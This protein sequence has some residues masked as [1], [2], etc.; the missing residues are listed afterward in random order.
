MAE[1]INEFEASELVFS[2]AGDDADP[3]RLVQVLPF[4][5]YWKESAKETLSSFVQ[6]FAK[7]W[8]QKLDDRCSRAPME[9]VEREAAKAEPEPTDA[10]K[11]AGNYAKGHVRLHGFDITIENAKGNTRSGEGKDGKKWSVKMPAAYGYIKGTKGKDKDHIDV[12]VGPDEKS[13]AVYVIDQQKKEGGFD[14]HKIMLGFKDRESAIE[15]YD[16][17]F[18]GDLGP[19]LRGAVTGASI[20][21]LK[22]WL[23]DGDTTKPYARALAEGSAK[24]FVKK[25]GR[26]LIWEWFP[27]GYFGFSSEIKRTEASGFVAWVIPE[28]HQYKVQWVTGAQVNPML[29][30]TLEAAQAAAEAAL[31][32]AVWVKE[33]AKQV[34]RQLFA[35]PW[36]Y[37]V[38][39]TPDYPGHYVASFTYRGRFVGCGATHK[40]PA[41][42][43]L[44]GNHYLKRFNAL[45][46][47]MPYDSGSF[48][49]C[50]S[51]LNRFELSPQAKWDAKEWKSADQERA[52]QDG[53]LLMRRD[54]GY[55]S[56][57]RY[58]AVSTF[59]NDAEAWR[60]VKAQAAMGS[61]LHQKA[62]NLVDDPALLRIGESAYLR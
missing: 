45:E 15:T 1:S 2:A 50:W 33:S 3:S 60:F 14:E 57:E 16:K 51:W 49:S 25:A 59:D 8:V 19:K 7:G 46:Q 44:D 38:E 54:D 22:Q 31:P 5:R 23:K 55:R 61:A 12:Y 41:A 36:G 27:D 24:D 32:P 39:A 34:L 35:K 26:R 40:D 62:V 11:E 20:A 53:W 9:S 56:V 42:A 13:E 47:R 30:P 28:A 43:E 18:I 37:E 52:M 17:A 10:Q 29:Y 58:D 6:Q 48:A 4:N 21:D